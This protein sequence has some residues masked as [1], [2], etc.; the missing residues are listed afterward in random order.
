MVCCHSTN[1]VTVN[2]IRW[3]FWNK[4][5]MENYGC[6]PKFSQSLTSLTLLRM[7]YFENESCIFSMF[8]LW[9]RHEFVSV[10][11]NWLSE[12]MIC[13]FISK[14]F[15]SGIMKCYIS[16]TICKIAIFWNSNCYFCGNMRKI[17]TLWNSNCYI[18]GSI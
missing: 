6:E 9:D 4:W 2:T 1:Y 12:K 3:I 5:A 18:C 11:V 8:V 13:C 14:S 10:L 15:S 16:G 7:K 17:A